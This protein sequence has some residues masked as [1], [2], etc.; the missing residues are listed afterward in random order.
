M[1]APK[2]I[3]A[4]ASPRRAKLLTDAGFEHAVVTSH[5]EEADQ[6]HLTAREIAQLNAYRKA[7]VVAKKHPAAA[8]LGSDT[9]VYLGTRLYG[10]PAHI[11]EAR[12]MLR[13]LAG[14]THEVVSG[15][16]LLH[17]ERHRCE[18]FFTSTQVTF[19]PLNRTQIHAYLGSINPFDKA[20]AYAIQDNGEAI[21]EAIH[22]SLT[23]VVGLPLAAVT[24]QL[25]TFGIT[26]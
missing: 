20:G 1:T 6:E 17:L 9:V 5:A 2:L 8:V 11:T 13:E 21:V 10:K 23:N 24:E 25:A 14:Q 7:R 3:L 18:I 12:R 16:C 4:S 26:N 15:C 22:G 19:R